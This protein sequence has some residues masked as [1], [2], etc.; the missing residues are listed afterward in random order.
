MRSTKGGNNFYEK[1][2]AELTSAKRVFIQSEVDP[3]AFHM[4]GIAVLCHV[5]HCLTFVRD[6][7]LINKFI[8]SLKEDVL[9]IDEGEVDRCVGVEI[10]SEDGAMTLKQPQLIK[11]IV[12]VLA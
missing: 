6:Q 12:D 5:A 9:Y 7:K 1:L 8:V 11:R 10:K 3:C 2:K 4:K